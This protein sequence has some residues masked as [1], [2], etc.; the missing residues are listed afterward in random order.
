M[1]APTIFGARHGLETLVQLLDLRTAHR[2]LQL[3][4]APVA[5]D[6]EPRFGF[7]GLMIDSA[8]H[9]LPV[10]HVKHVVA[11]A[12]QVCACAKSLRMCT[13]IVRFAVTTWPLTID[14]H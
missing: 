4:S 12:A 10:A 3:R 7:R 8:R 14:L 2:P 9:F 5:I 11:A 6:D 13:S 1:H